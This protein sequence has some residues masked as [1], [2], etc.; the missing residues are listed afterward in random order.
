MTDLDSSLSSLPEDRE[1]LRTLVETL[2]WEREQ[3]Q[4][5]AEVQQ[6]RAEEQQHLIEEQR[7]KTAQLE[8]EVLR[9]Q[10]ELERYKRWYYGPRADRLRTEGE[11][12]QLLL[13]FAEELDQKPLPTVKVGQSAESAERRVQRR[14]GRRALARF[15]HLPVTTHVYELSEA[16]RACPGCGQTRKEIGAEESWQLEYIP[17]HFERL[18]HVRKKY[19]CPR[20]ESQGE[21]PQITTVAKPETAIDKGL[22]GPGSLAYIV[23]SKFSDYLP[24][25]RL[26]DVFTRQGFAISRGT[27]SVWCRDVAD[28][29]EPLYDLM[30][31]G[32]C[33]SHVIATDDTILPLLQ[34]AR[35]PASACGSMW[36]TPRSPTTS[37]TS[38]STAAATARCAF[39]RTTIKS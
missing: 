20:C 16:E 3:H 6:H 14:K 29:A 38:R 1:A 9:L 32:V 13:Q 35:P 22:A 17:G 33:S 5:Q 26:E 7:Q 37:L 23:T 8:A 15:E 39:S 18:Q 24:L 19:A 27:Q 10:V 2:L 36:A 31:E 4:Q 30:A 21:S 28:L 25:Y 12:A 34:K 11:W